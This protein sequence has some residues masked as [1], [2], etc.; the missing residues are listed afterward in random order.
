[1]SFLGTELQLW[2]TS[3]G[4]VCVVYEVGQDQRIKRAQNVMP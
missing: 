3:F 4:V 2:H 1:M